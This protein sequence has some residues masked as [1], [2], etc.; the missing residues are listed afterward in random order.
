MSVAFNTEAVVLWQVKDWHLTEWTD[1]SMPK[2]INTSLS[3]S[4]VQAIL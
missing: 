3:F 2:S 1:D 4:N